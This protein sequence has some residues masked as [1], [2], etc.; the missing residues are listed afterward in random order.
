M[1]H[2]SIYRGSNSLKKKSIRNYELRLYFGLSRLHFV[3]SEINEREARR[4][5]GQL[6]LLMICIILFGVSQ[7]LF[8]LNIKTH[9]IYISA[10]QTQGLWQLAPMGRMQ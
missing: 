2:K 7:I 9:D 3:R 8:A 1:I 6:R 10:Y 5:E 4:R